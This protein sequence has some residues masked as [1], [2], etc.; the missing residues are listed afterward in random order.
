MHTARARS[1]VV[2][3]L[4]AGNGGL[5]TAADLT[6]RGHTVR[7]YDLPEFGRPLH[8]VRDHGIQVEGALAPGVYRPA[9]VT[10]AIEEALDGAQVL[11]L[12]VPGYAQARFAELLHPHLSDTHVLLV[13]PGGV[14]GA[15]EMSQQLRRTRP[16]CRALIGESA[17]LIYAAKRLESGAGGPARV[18]VNGVK[19]GVPVAAIP[20]ARTPEMLDALASVMPGATAARDVLDTGLNNINIIV[21]PVLVLT[22]LTR[23]EAA[24]DWFI[25]RNGFTPAVARMMEA[26]DR[27]RLATLRALQLPT[28]ALVEWMLRF[29]AN[30]GVRGRELHDVLSTA[31][32]FQR[33]MGP[34]ALHDRYL[35]ED[36]PYGLVP[37]ASIARA[38]D[39]ATP[40]TDAVIDLASVVRETD[41]RAGGRTLER[42]GLA[43]VT[44][45][46]LAALLARGG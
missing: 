31:P 23:V 24:E 35:D 36:V 46:E 2:A 41:F 34:K 27:E 10:T 12:T 7:L 1:Q 26:V 4:G 44:P 17:N 21:H 45:R 5:A 20:A 15:L 32:V 38:L 16:S 18:R 14:G 22:N 30:Q 9:V 11:L 13:N 39:V 25:F 19:R 40:H 3:V 42:M 43:D 8:A 28:V 29:Y 37:L 33:S 6:A